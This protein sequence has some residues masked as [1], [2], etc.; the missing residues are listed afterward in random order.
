MREW[1]RN[2]SPRRAAAWGA[3]TLLLFGTA[4]MAGTCPAVEKSAP[5]TEERFGAVHWYDPGLRGGVDTG[6]SPRISR[7]ASFMAIY[8]ATGT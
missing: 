3:A 4:G 5:L 7:T 8:C 1:L 2:L 6:Y